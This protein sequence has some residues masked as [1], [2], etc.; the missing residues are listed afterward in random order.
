MSKTIITNEEN[1]DYG[2]ELMAWQIPSRETYTRGLWWYIITGVVLVTM[3]VYGIWTAN[4]LFVILIA[5]FIF[6]NLVNYFRPAPQ[7]DFIITSQGF[8]ID[9]KF[10]DYDVAKNFCVIYKPRENLR[11]LYLEFNGI[12]KPR[13]TIPL[14]NNNPLEV[15]QHLL[16][17]ISENLDRTDEPNTDYLAKRLKF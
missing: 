14:L 17:Y 5:L 2:Q 13:L 4:Y 15:R 8:I 1:S 12:L 9:D 7:I 16:N 10:Y 11:A 3:V 6:I